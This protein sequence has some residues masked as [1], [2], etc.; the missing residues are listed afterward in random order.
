MYYQE[1]CF[2]LCVAF[3][4]SLQVYLEVLLAV[5]GKKDEKLMI[6]ASLQGGRQTVYK[7]G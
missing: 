2:L 3:P 6:N 5:P 1:S 4:W 7:A